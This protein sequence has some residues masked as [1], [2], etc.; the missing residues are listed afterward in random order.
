MSAELFGQTQSEKLATDN[1]AARQI[2][3]EINLF[4]INDRQRW[5]IIHLLSLELENI[6]EMKSLSKFISDM[7]GK[8][9]FVSRV[10][11]DD[12]PTDTNEDLV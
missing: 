4:G 9:L 11:S 6:D 8:E 3:R 7:K 1:N 5:L 12:S 10:F 2:V